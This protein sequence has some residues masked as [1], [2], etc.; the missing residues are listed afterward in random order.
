[1]VLPRGWALKKGSLWR[2]EIWPWY[3][4]VPL[5]VDWITTPPPVL[6]YLAGTPLVITVTSPTIA[7][8]TVRAVRPMLAWVTLE[9]S[10][11]MEVAPGMPPET[12]VAAPGATLAV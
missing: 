3:S 4:L 10:T 8:E 1:M 11:M 12:L 5:R 9:P 7:P 6:P 2:H